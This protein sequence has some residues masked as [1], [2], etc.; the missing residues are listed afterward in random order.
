MLTLN[1]FSFG[2]NYYIQTN[3]VAMGTKTHMDPATPIFL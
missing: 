2:G 3:G 1:R